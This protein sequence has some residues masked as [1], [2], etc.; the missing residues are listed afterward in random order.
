[1]PFALALI[2][3]LFCW[4]FGLPG[5]VAAFFALQKLIPIHKTKKGGKGISA[6]K[7]KW[8]YFLAW[9]GLVLSLVFTVYYCI[10]LVTGAFVRL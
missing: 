10:A 6:F 9:S 4:F 3:V 5:L 1:M 2:S 7:I 8:G